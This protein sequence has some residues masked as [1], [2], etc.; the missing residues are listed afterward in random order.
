L[1]SLS[2]WAAVGRF[3]SGGG[4]DECGPAGVPR[5]SLAVVVLPAVRV[6]HHANGRLAGDRALPSVPGA[7]AC[8]G[9]A[10]VLAID[11]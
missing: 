9:R 3:G 4:G 2:G 5:L 11:R 1:V 10:D 8:R 7:C 6:E